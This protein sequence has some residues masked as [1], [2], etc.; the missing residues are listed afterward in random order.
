MR[1]IL[2]ILAIICGI[3]LI[4]KLDTGTLDPQ[5]VAGIGLVF[6]GLAVVAPA[7]WPVMP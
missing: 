3:A 4:I 5:Q 6:L 7:N 2:V 1:F